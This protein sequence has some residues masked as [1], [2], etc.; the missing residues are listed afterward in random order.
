[1]LGSVRDTVRA[2]DQQLQRSEQEKRD[3]IRDKELKLR[4]LD[5][6]ISALRTMNALGKNKTNN[7]DIHTSS[8]VLS[9]SRKSK[10]RD[11]K[12]KRTEKDKSLEIPA[13][14]FCPITQS[15]MIDPVMNE[16]GQTYERKSIQRWYQT[17]RKDPLTNVNII[18]GKLLPN[19]NLR[20]SIEE[21]RRTH[22]VDD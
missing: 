22:D 1:M 8:G 17:S 16:A 11:D 2:R 6:N 3:E 5:L 10:E 12:I 21:Y 14:F 20:D 18:T 19:I 15:I 9:V 4:T 13:Q 7:G